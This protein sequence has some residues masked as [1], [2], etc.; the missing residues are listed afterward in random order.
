MN[1][2][3]SNFS[4]LNQH[5]FFLILRHVCI[6]LAGAPPHP[7]PGPHGHRL[8]F[9]TLYHRTEREGDTSLLFRL[10]LRFLWSEKGLSLYINT[11]RRHQV[12]GSMILV[13]SSYVYL[14]GEGT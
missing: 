9:L 13:S 12:Q 1:K 3:N 8:H 6:T 14:F 2:Q 7:H 5:S 10:L 4:G 11:S